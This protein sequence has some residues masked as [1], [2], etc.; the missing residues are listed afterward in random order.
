MMLLMLASG[1]PVMPFL[2]SS[3][4]LRLGV[5]LWVLFGH[6]RGEGG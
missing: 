2:H 4:A 3:R 5:A 1:G 6:V